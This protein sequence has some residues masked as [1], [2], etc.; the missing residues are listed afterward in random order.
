MPSQVNP[1]ITDAIA[2]TNTE[3]IGM[4]PAVAVSYL[5]QATAQALANAAHNATQAQRNGEILDNATT[6]TGVAII[7]SLAPKGK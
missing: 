3:V 4:S 2:N 1:E 7:Q 6:A 5:Y